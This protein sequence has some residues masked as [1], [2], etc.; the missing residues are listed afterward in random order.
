[1]LNLCSGQCFTVSLPLD[2]DF[3]RSMVE[4]VPGL[5]WSGLD[6]EMPIIFYFLES[7]TETHP[8]LHWSYFTLSLLLDTE[9]QY[10][11]VQV[12]LIF[13]CTDSFLRAAVLL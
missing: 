12:K 2:T 5:L 10:Q 6:Q 3:L 11:T 9:I 8:G 7:L 4:R 1:M 13:Y